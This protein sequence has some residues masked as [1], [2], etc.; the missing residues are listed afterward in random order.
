M[1]FFDT[2][3][4]GRILNRFSQDQNDIDQQLPT[5][6][7]AGLIVCVRCLSIVILTCIPQPKPSRDMQEARKDK[8]RR[9]M[10]FS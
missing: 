4:I 5:S 3:P 8:L 10:L 7:E 6:F 9:T 2:T 1:S